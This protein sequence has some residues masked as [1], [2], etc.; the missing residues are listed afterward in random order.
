MKQ[1]RVV[2][3]LEH[4][5]LIKHFYVGWS[6]EEFGAPEID[7]KRPYG[8]SD[9]YSDIA[10]I[11]ELDE[12]KNIDHLVKVHSDLKDV[13]QICLM[14]QRFETGVFERS[15]EYNSRSWIKVAD[16]YEANNYE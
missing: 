1:Q 7:P 8:N 2:I 11:L 5:K 15:D 9:V 16:L 3:T 12:E 4:L 10:K 14:R 13:L 6:S